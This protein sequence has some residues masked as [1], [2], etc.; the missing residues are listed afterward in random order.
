MFQPVKPQAMMYAT[1]MTVTTAAF[2]SRLESL[3]RPRAA[4][5]CLISSREPRGFMFLVL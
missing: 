3:N 4:Y 2:F 1:M 5:C